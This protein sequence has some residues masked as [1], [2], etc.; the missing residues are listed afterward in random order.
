MLICV[1]FAAHLLIVLNAGGLQPALVLDYDAFKT[2]PFVII[3]CTPCNVNRI[4][5]V[6]CCFGVNSVG[7]QSLPTA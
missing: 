7:F 1:V 5:V 6:S 2:N 4:G 3:G